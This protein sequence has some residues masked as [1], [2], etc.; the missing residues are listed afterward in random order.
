MKK[1]FLSIFLALCMVLT[2]FPAYALAAEST[3]TIQGTVVD[4]ET[5]KPIEIEVIVSLYARDDFNTVLAY[6]TCDSNTGAYTLALSE[7]ISIGQYTLVFTSDLYLSRSMD[8]DLTSHDGLVIAAATG[9]YP[10][11]RCDGTVT[12][13]TTGAA[14]SGVTVN[15]YKTSGDLNAST[16]TDMDGKYS[17]ETQAGIYDIEFVKNGY[18]TAKVEGVSLGAIVVTHDMQMT[19]RHVNSNIWDGSIAENFA[20]GSGTKDDPYQ[21]EN[22]AQLAKL[23]S[24]M[25]AGNYYVLTSDIYLN[26][27]ASENWYEDENVNAWASIVDFNGTFDGQ[28]HYIYG[29]YPTCLFEK[30]R[31]TLQNINIAEAM[32]TE[33]HVGGSSEHIGAIAGEAENVIGCSNSG[34]I[35]YSNHS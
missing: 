19:A 32:I 6:T 14:L 9:L 34:T 10:I 5:Q 15:V 8:I 16:T 13:A 30:A 7:D 17:I 2:A 31:G 35:S 27:T 29:L 25:K 3:G 33:G 21:I 28:G 23:S 24:G 18:G 1:R 26:E 11:G 20:G 12:D 4:I 22:G